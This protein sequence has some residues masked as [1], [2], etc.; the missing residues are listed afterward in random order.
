[1]DVV[2]AIDEQLKQVY[3]HFRGELEFDFTYDNGRGE[4]NFYDLNTY[5]AVP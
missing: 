2:G 5:V 3:P 4:F 1:M